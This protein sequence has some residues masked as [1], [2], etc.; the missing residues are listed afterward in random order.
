[1]KG[2]IVCLAGLA[3]LTA[4]G[5]AD[6]Q[7]AVAQGATPAPAAAP[8]ITVVG[9]GGKTVQL[10]P[11]ALADLPQ[12]EAMLREGAKATPYEG[13]T[14]SAVLRESGTPVGPRAHGAPMKAFVE[15][16]GADGYKIVLS[17]AETDPEFRTGAIVLADEVAKAPID[18]RQGPYRLV[19]GDDPKP[20]RAV[21]N[22]VK[23]EVL[24]AP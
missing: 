11:A 12:G 3:V 21:R 16:I 19:I 6:A 7:G 2:L 5:A 13:P 4:T 8:G 15:V 14:L 1:M 24:S 22:V 23:I 17:L 9:L 10:S 18:A 20:W